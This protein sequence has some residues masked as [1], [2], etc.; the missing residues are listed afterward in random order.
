MVR[1]KCKRYQY[2]TLA[3]YELICSNGAGG[4]QSTTFN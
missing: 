2:A 3:I 4:A 1:G